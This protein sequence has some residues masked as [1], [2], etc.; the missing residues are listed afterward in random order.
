M[1]WRTV[2]SHDGR[3]IRRRRA[4][5]F[6]AA[7]RWLTKLLTGHAPT[8]AAFAWIDAPDGLSATTFLPTRTGWV[9][10]RPSGQVGLF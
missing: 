6:E 3:T 4:P 10:R 8:P 9:E 5:T 7:L 1:T 2:F